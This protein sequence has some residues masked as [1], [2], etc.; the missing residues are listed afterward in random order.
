MSAFD[1]ILGTSYRHFNQLLYVVEEAGYL[2]RLYELRSLFVEAWVSRFRNLEVRSTQRAESLNR[3][4]KRTLR[5]D[6]PL[7]DLFHALLKMGK[8]VEETRA[9]MSF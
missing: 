4:F 3:A 1:Q 2:E 9:F 7:M 5:T 8:R 6:C